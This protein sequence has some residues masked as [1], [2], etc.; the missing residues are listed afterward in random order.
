M[1]VA[2]TPAP[3]TVLRALEV[4]TQ[5][6]GFIQHP[7]VIH[8]PDTSHSSFYPLAAN[9]NLGNGPIPEGAVMILSTPPARPM[10]TPDAVREIY[11][12]LENYGAVVGTT[13]TKGYAY[14]DGEAIY[15]EKY[16]NPNYPEDWG[17]NGLNV[18]EYSLS[19]ATWLDGNQNPNFTF[20]R[21]GEIPQPPLQ[22][23]PGPS[24]T[25][26]NGPCENSPG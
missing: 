4:D 10:D 20:L 1:T 14:I 8:V 2:T 24:P 19:A 7:L 16:A 11:H 9:D 12:A 6:G 5:H 13:S 17:N 18:H 3:Y 23:Y 15:N 21:H 25:Q 22:N 26:W